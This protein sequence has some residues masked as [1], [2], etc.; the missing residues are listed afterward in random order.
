MLFQLTV[1]DIE[2]DEFLVVDDLAHHFYDSV[3]FE[4]YR[5]YMPYV[6][7]HEFHRLVLEYDG[8]KFLGHEYELMYSYSSLRSLEVAQLASSRFPLA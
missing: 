6:V 8:L 5:I 1:V 2:S 7:L 4:R 3:S